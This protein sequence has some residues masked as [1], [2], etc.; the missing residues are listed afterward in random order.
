[1][2][3][4]REF[5]KYQEAV[6]KVKEIKGFYSHLISYI[7]TNLFFL[8]INLKYSP[9]VYWF[10]WPMFSWGIGLFFHGM[11]V[12]GYFPFFSKDW[13]ERKIKEFIEQEKSNKK[14]NEHN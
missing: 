6:K 2:E 10:F 9:E 1:M 12:F 3:T 13:E 14:H 11:R 7:G 4:N 8:F 5:Q